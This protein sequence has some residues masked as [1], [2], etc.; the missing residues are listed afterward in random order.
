MNLLLA[1]SGGVDSMYLAWKSRELFPNMKIAVAHCNFLLRGVE[2]DGDEAFVREWCEANGVCF[3]HRSFDTA[4]YAAGNGVSI[5]MAARTLRYSWFSELCKGSAP[6]LAGSGFDGFYGVAVAHNANDNAETLLLNMLRGTG[7]RGLRGMSRES[8][9]ESMDGL[10]IIRPLLAVERSEIRSWMEA[11]GHGW[12]EDRTNGENDYKR[13]RIR[14]QVFPILETINPSFIR[15]LGR[16]MAHLAQ[17]DDIA[18]ELYMNARPSLIRE[19]GRIDLKDLMAN[20]HWKY[21]LWRLIEPYHLSE[22]TFGK[23]TELLESGRTISGKSFESPTHI[24]SI[25]KKTMAAEPRKK[26]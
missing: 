14:N 11:N 7:S 23:L 1:V 2:S 16:D 17:V 20:R 4:G 9:M 10:R 21:L 8:V 26:D 15:T 3:L 25:H 5:E 18:E 13:N 24:L 6:E 12:R 22:E 19:D